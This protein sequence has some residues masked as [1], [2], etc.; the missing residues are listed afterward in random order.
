MEHID[1]NSDQAAKFVTNLEGWVD[2]QGRF[3]GDDEHM[4][5]WS[6]ATH[7]PC[8]K[9]ETPTKKGFT[10]CESCREQN[11]IERYK[12]LEKVIWDG[13]T[14]LYSEAHDEWFFDE[15]SILDYLFEHET[16]PTKLR[17][18]TSSPQYL[19]ELDID[20][21]VDVLPED[22]YCL[23]DEV[24]EAMEAF[25]KVIRK[26]KPVSWVPGQYAAIVEVDGG[27]S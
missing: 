27:P 4:A 22:D 23:P 18:V 15:E 9:C 11:K 2:R 12:A 3:W 16:T 14:P 6:G 20:Y 25:N 19:N 1:Y 26:S 5:R 13:K 17:L 7:I 24:E 10:Q 21:F 8:D